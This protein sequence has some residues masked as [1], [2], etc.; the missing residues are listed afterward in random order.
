MYGK[1]WKH[2]QEHVGTRT[3]TQARS[4]AQKF[5]QKL[6]KRNKT[7]DEFLSTLDVDNMESHYIMEDDD[8]DKPQNSQKA[9][10]GRA[11]QKKK[12]SEVKE[13][14]KTEVD[15]NESGMRA[16]KWR[17]HESAKAVLQPES[18]Q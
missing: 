14:E 10:R 8:E 16:R 11:A 3:S 1:D 12:T 2:V 4:H 13:L 6:E 5:F 18:F 9:P 7:L 15:V 17:R